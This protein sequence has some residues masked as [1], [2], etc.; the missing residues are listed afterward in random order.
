MS[1]NKNDDTKLIVKEDEKQLLL[2]H[3]YDG[4]QELNHPLP[5]W[6]NF[7]FYA[8]IVYSVGYFI[9]YQFLNGPTLK[10]EL[11]KITLLF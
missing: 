10:E 9:Y 6:W 4:I 3:N 1:H 5:S 8:A 2:D 11:T 7:I